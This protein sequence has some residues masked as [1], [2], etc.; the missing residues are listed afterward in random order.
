MGWLIDPNAT[1]VQT[2]PAASARRVCTPLRLGRVSSLKCCTI[3]HSFSNA[4]QA[5]LGSRLMA[6]YWSYSIAGSGLPVEPPGRLGFAC[7][8]S[9]RADQHWTQFRAGDH[10]QQVGLRCTGRKQCERAVPRTPGRMWKAWIHM[11]C[12]FRSVTSFRY[13]RRLEL[14]E[15]KGSR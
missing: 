12:I 4:L 2:E 8:L 9:H 10:V 3:V 13:G 15:R 1:N 5:T 6:P 11:W 14:V 7:I